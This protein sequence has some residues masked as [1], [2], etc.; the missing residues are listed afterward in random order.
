MKAY[1]KSCRSNNVEFVVQGEKKPIYFVPEG[2]DVFCFDESSLNNSLLLTAFPIAMK[3][4]L[5]LEVEGSFDPLLIKNLEKVSEMWWRWRPDKFSRPVRIVEKGC[6]KQE[7]RSYSVDLDSSIMAFSGG[8]DSTYALLRYNEKNPDK[9]IKKCVMINGF[10]YDLS[11]SS[12]YG[13]QY[14]KNKSFLEKED[15]YLYSARTNYKNIVA[16]YPFFHAMGIAAVLNLYAKENRVGAVGLD[17]D[18]DEER[19]LGPW[20]NLFVLNTLY[21]ASSFFIEPIGGDKNRVE[22]I[23][24]LHQHGMLS[25]VTVC[26]NVERYGRNCGV[27]EKCIRTMLTCDI[28]N[29]EYESIFG[30]AVLNKDI[31]KLKISKPTQYIFYTTLLKHIEDGQAVKKIIEEKVEDYRLN[32]G[33]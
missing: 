24:Y 1:I 12:A 9:K 31:E 20:G 15:V 18:Y 16:W 28:K 8:V 30:R 33:A 7:T 21:S 27:C 19:N 25:S 22:K 17:Y 26:N 4:G 11:E 14:E 5:D 32:K 29:V 13:K 3:K 6:N 23:A 2:G 10:G